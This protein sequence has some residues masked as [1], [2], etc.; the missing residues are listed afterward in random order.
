M[1]IGGV[2][3]YGLAAVLWPLTYI[4]E[5]MINAFYYYAWHYL[6]EPLGMTAHVGVF[7]VL[8]VQIV[9]RPTKEYWIFLGVYTVVEVGLL[10]LF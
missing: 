8:L 10:W 5:S 4:G 6:G 7:F 9:K 3:T 2:V 1:W